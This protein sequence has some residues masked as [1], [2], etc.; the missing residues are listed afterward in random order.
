MVV[1]H[2]LSTADVPIV[3][4]HFGLPLMAVCIYAL[5]CAASRVL[6]R[7]IQ[8]VYSHVTHAIIACFFLRF[9]WIR[10]YNFSLFLNRQ[11]LIYCF[12]SASCMVRNSIS[13]YIFLLL[14][15]VYSRVSAKLCSV[16]LSI[17]GC[18]SLKVCI[19]LA[20]S[21]VT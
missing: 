16:Q 18:C 12:C 7:N 15:A 9:G 14:A 13:I 17:S 10:V 20:I 2:S 21:G 4:M 6:Y 19:L 8:S 11:D 5:T 1:I 3:I